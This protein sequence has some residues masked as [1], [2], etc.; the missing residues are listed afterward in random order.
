[1]WFTAHARL[2]GSKFIP[3]AYS[4]GPYE[5]IL[6]SQH[7]VCDSGKGEG[8]ERGE[9]E[10]WVLTKWTTVQY[11]WVTIS[12]D[13]ERWFCS[14]HLAFPRQHRHNR[15][16]S[17]ARS[18]RLSPYGSEGVFITSFV[19]LPSPTHTQGLSIFSLF[20]LRSFIAIWCWVTVP[21]LFLLCG[22]P[23]RCWGITREALLY[24]VVYVAPT[25]V[26]FCI[27]TFVKPLKFLHSVAHWNGSSS[28]PFITSL[29]DNHRRWFY[30]YSSGL[31]LNP[32]SFA[33]L[34]CVLM[35]WV[36]VIGQ[37]NNQTTC[38]SIHDLTR[39]SK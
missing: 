34:Y 37:S 6:T 10:I 31:T 27:Y 19:S 11:R 4:R 16:F 25:V 12:H 8:G 3:H 9:R 26:Q 32:T 28:K 39:I 13:D 1:M 29:L 30:F 15:S 14:C 35:H 36:N 2:L 24:I 38:F 21:G 18:G 22:S 23:S 20:L 5:Y 7:T 17:S 33:Q